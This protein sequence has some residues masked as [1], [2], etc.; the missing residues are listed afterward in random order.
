MLADG[1]AKRTLLRP[2][3]ELAHDVNSCGTR[4]PRCR[5]AWL[6]HVGP[7]NRKTSTVLAPLH[8]SRIHRAQALTGHMR[9]QYTTEP[10]Y[11]V[12]AR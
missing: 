5:S 6:G 9:K 4:I 10:N 3:L 12:I 8:Q 11:N 7:V 1:L 2:R